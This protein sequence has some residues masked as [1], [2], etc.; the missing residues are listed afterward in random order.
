MFSDKLQ[1][2]GGDMLLKAGFV[3]LGPDLLLEGQDGETVLRKGFFAQATS[4]ELWTESGARITADLAVKLADPVSD[5]DDFIQREKRWQAK[6]Q[7]R[8]AA[9]ID[10]VMEELIWIFETRSV[11]PPPLPRRSSKRYQQPP[12][13]NWPPRKGRIRQAPPQP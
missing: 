11:S 5:K 3:R 7:H 4:P 12:E 9:R 10:R 2:P 6:E 13:P 1:V 8:I